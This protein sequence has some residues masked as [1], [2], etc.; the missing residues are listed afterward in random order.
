MIQDINHP[1]FGYAESTPPR[2]GNK[3]GGTKPPK[4]L[5]VHC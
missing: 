1:V 4:L 2:E 3:K 5:T